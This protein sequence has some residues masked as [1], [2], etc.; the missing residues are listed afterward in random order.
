MVMVVRHL[1]LRFAIPAAGLLGMVVLVLLYQFDP[2]SYYLTLAFF[3]IAPV[4][5]PPFLDFQFVLAS[6]DCW[7]HGIDVYINN[8]CDVLERPF[9]YSPLWL[10]FTFL[11]DKDSTNPLGLYLGISFFLALAVLPPPRSG[12]EL[13]LRLVAS[14][15]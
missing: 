7:Q 8:P 14:L 6:I 10:R 9:D 4:R 12:K 3:G 13:L 1:A 11:A 15:R 5:Y 2:Q